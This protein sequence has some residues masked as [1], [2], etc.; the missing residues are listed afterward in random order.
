MAKVTD[1]KTLKRRQTRRRTLKLLA[2]IAAI[3]V[4]TYLLSSIVNTPSFAGLSSVLD[5]IKGGPGYP[6]DAPGGKVQGMYQNG[7]SLVVLNETNL[8]FYN[9][10]GS[11]AYRVQH[12]MGNPQVASNG[13]ML[14]NYDRGSKTYA[15]YSRNNLFYSG[16]TENAIRAGDISQNG[17]IAIATQ[18]ENAQTHVMVMDAKQ[19]ELYTWKSDNVVTALAISANGSGVAIGSSYVEEGQLKSALTVLKNG[20]E[21]TRYE[22][23]N[24]MIYALEFDGANVRCI[25][26]KNAFL[27]GTEGR[28]IGQFDYK[29]QQLAAFSMYENGVALVFGN[30]EQDR[31]YTLA[32]VADDFYT[33]NGQT[34]L[35]D[36][37]Q[38]VKAYEHTI[39]VLGASSFQEYSAYD[40][41]RIG[42][43]DEGSYYDIQP[44]G[45]S[46][47]AMTTTEIMR[48]P[49]QSPSKF[50]L[51]GAGK[52]QELPDKEDGAPTQEELDLLQNLLNKM[53]QE[54]D[55][56][57]E[58]EL[59][60]GQS[61]PQTVYE[62]GFIEVEEPKAPQSEP[63][64][65]EL[66]GSEP[67]GSEP[68][69]PKEGLNDAYNRENPD[70]VL[71]EGPAQVPVQNEDVKPSFTEEKSDQPQEENT[72]RRPAASAQ[73]E[74]SDSDRSEPEGDSTREEDDSDRE[75]EPLFSSRRPAQ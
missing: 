14:L 25:T 7:G 66:E 65:T 17:C 27:L 10:S 4:G 36:S 13:T 40:C 59:T 51:F 5:M 55:Q 63:E 1:F 28:M 42:G 39:L 73:P 26:D 44:M 56:L 75:E 30:Y 72:G 8:Y 57:P 49:L 43:E 24:Q 2:L 61:E 60:V 52:P 46:V 32:S 54:A 12:R 22:L 35:T 37:L 11:E 3:L 62:E 69:L 74:R 16:K 34:T 19:R 9:T 29:G 68:D 58:E 70:G 6:I 71:N 20:K 53:E 47:Y 64:Q 41:S 15:A 38:R 23:A 48:L 33:L 50:S 45:N 18:T 21:Q 31:K 67:E